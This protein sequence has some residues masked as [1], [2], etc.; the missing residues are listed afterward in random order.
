MRSNQNYANVRPHDDTPAH[1]SASH[2]DRVSLGCAADPPEKCAATDLATDLSTALLQAANDSRGR[3]DYKAT[4]TLYKQSHAAAP[5]RPLPLISLGQ[6][7]SLS[8]SPREAAD[9]FRKALIMDPYNTNA[10]RGLGN[11]MVAINQPELATG[12]YDKA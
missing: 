11:A 8:G 5:K 12:H 2:A 6:V 4:A 7:L 3:G 1:N 10:N 9:A